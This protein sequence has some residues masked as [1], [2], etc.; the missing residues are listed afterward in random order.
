MGFVIALE[1]FQLRLAQSCFLIGRT[2]EPTRFKILKFFENQPKISPP[3]Q[4]EAFLPWIEPIDTL[5]I[6]LLDSKSFRA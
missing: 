2:C 4:N 6:D 3:A 1:S 5:V